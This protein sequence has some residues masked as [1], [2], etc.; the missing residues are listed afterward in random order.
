MPAKPVS[1]KQRPWTVAW[2]SILVLVGF[3]VIICAVVVSARR[4]G[5]LSPFEQLLFSVLMLVLSTGGSA[6]MAEHYARR[7]GIREYQQLA[8]PALRRVTEL[9]GSVNGIQRYLLE[10]RGLL[11]SGQSPALEV[12]QEWL[13]GALTLLEAQGGQL[14]ASVADW[15]ELLPADYQMLQGVLQRQ[16]QIEALRVLEGTLSAREETDEATRKH[17]AE[18]QEQIARLQ[19]DQ[20]MRPGTA[21][22]LFGN[23][24]PLTY[25]DIPMA[26]RSM[27]ER[28]AA[29]NPPGTVVSGLQT[30]QPREQPQPA[31]DAPRR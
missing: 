10:R 30:L 13:D 15:Q 20:V 28:L 3:L 14:R 11:V 17:L 27:T 8:R 7:Q 25:Q 22:L 31:A 24:S 9:Q 29:E 26:G 16:D 5:G 21:N 1:D 12:V 6:L 19:V 2:G 4:E 23:H 18:L